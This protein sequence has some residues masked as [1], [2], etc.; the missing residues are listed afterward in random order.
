[1][2]GNVFVKRGD[3]ERFAVVRFGGDGTG[4]SLGRYRFAFN[5]V[6]VAPGSTSA[7]FRLFSGLESVGDAQQRLRD[8]RRWGG[9]PPARG[10]GGVD[11]RARR[12]GHEQLGAH[13]LDQRASGWTD[14][15]MGGDPGLVEIDDLG[16]LDPA[17]ASR[18]SPVVDTGLSPPPVFAAH[19]FDRPLNRPPDSPVHGVGRVVRP[20]V[21]TIDRGAYEHGSGPPPPPDGGSPG[22][23][24]G[25]PGDDAGDDARPRRGRPD[26]RR[27]R[28]RRQRAARGRRRSA[29]ERGR[30]RLPRGGP[31]RAPRRLRPARRRPRLRAPPPARLIRS[32]A[33]ARSGRRPRR[34]CASSGTSPPRVRRTA[35]RSRC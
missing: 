29:P 14:T 27:L 17:P 35:A 22:G 15:L 7:V 6:I 34:R 31:P 13:R 10:G 2:V 20:V 21:G 12:R 9:E 33:P 16:A 30:V 19:P 11:R 4:Q 28:R 3:N 32:G 18:S 5:T 8:A 26:R 23:D 24:A 1:M 25:S